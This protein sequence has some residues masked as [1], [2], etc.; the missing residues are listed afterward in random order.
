MVLL[1]M[2][3][4]YAF[5]RSLLPSEL[6]ARPA[7]RVPPL[8]RGALQLALG[9]ESR[10]TVARLHMDRLQERRLLPHEALTRWRMRVLALD[11][12]LRIHFSADEVVDAYAERVPVGD[13]RVGLAAESQALFGKPLHE[14][15][16]HEVAVLA[17][18]AWAPERLDPA[19]RTEDAREARDA[20]LGHMVDARLLAGDALAAQRAMPVRVLV[21]CLEP[22]AP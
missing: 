16:P 8:V 18:V 13:D 17:G 10:R 15:A 12:W 11:A 20:F 21:P 3:G 9:K 22:T 19:C 14:L 1:L 5:Y 7:T 4:A 2:G 6:P